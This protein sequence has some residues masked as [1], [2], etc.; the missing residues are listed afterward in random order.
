MKVKLILKMEINENNYGCEILGKRTK[1][2]ILK[3]R[4][5][6]CK[7]KQKGTLLLII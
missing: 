4:G 1:L 3:V 5:L 6:N 7:F 2:K